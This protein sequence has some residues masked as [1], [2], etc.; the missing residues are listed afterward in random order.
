MLPVDDDHR[1]YAAAVSVPKAKT[2][3][4]QSVVI[5]DTHL[6]DALRQHL[7]GMGAN[8]SAFGFS[9]WQLAERIREVLRDWGLD[10]TFVPLHS[11]RQGGATADHLR[12]ATVDGRAM[13]FEDIMNRGRWNINP[14]ARR[15][16]QMGRSLMLGVRLPDDL[17]RAGRQLL[18]RRDVLVRVLKV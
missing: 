4:H 14:S 6:L 1:R 17:S 7:R 9:R 15:Y 16:L 18:T 11:L 5:V 2:G 12:G 13:L 10:Q 8:E 3:L